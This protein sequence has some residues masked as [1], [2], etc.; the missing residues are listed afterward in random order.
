MDFIAI[1]TKT[2]PYLIIFLVMVIENRDQLGLKKEEYM[3]RHLELH[4]VQTMA[5]GGTEAEEVLISVVAK[6]M[7]VTEV[8][9]SS[10]LE[11]FMV[12]SEEVLGGKKFADFDTGKTTKLLH[13]GQTSL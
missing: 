6:G 1:I 12:G 13:H 8:V 2:N 5:V 11:D 9:P 7:V 10:P 4:F 3:P